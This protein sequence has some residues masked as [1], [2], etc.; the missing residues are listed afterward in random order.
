MQLD[1]AKAFANESPPSLFLMGNS[2]AFELEPMLREL[3]TPSVKGR[4][5]VGEV[6]F[7]AWR[8]SRDSLGA[9]GGKL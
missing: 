4:W 9:R 8:L 5:C 1:L 6:Q 7:M 2:A 3:A